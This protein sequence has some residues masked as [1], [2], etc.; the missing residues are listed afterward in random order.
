VRRAATLDRHLRMHAA[1]VAVARDKQTD[2]WTELW[3]VQ[4]ERHDIHR[5]FVIACSFSVRAY[6]QIAI[7]YSVRRRRL[8]STT[9]LRCSELRRFFG[10]QEIANQLAVPDATDHARTM[11]LILASH[12]AYE[13]PLRHAGIANVPPTSHL[14]VYIEFNFFKRVLIRTLFRSFFS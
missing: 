12:L 2:R 5:R 10:G 3:T 8:H 1:A 13:I 11:S 9:T 7:F 14:S 6:T 4:K